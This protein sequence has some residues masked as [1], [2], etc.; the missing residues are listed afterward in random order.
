MTLP[1]GLVS[2]K[3]PRQSAKD[4]KDAKKSES[5]NPFAIF[6]SFADP[7]LLLLPRPG[8]RGFAL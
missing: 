5:E 8:F 7:S 3:K 1:S 6:A 4:A 2:W